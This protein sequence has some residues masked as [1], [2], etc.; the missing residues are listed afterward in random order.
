MEVAEIFAVSR[1]SCSSYLTGSANTMDG[2][3]TASFRRSE[4]CRLQYRRCVV[5]GIEE[6]RKLGILCSNSIVLAAV[7]IYSYFCVVHRHI[8]FGQQGS[9]GTLLVQ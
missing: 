3:V 8:A 4:V 1:G 5:G 6:L 2:V 9:L 7:G